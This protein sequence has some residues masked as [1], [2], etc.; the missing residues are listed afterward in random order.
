MT[1]PLIVRQHHRKCPRLQFWDAGEHECPC[2]CPP[3][4]PRWIGTDGGR[5]VVGRKACERMKKGSTHE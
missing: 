1:E 4:W 5:T 2:D 3:G